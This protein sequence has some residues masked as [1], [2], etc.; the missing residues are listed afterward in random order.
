MDDSGI[1]SNSQF[2]IQSFRIADLALDLG[3]PRLESLLT[4]FD[5]FQPLLMLG[6]Y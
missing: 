3:F 1:S 4:T 5:V 2:G 6:K